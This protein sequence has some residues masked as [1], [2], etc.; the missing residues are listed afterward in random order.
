MQATYF[1]KVVFK[2]QTCKINNTVLKDNFSLLKLLKS[3][4]I[5]LIHPIQWTIANMISVDRPAKCQKKTSCV[6]TGQACPVLC[7]R[8]VA[9]RTPCQDSVTSWHLFRLACVLCR[10]IIICVSKFLWNIVEFLWNSLLF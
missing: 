2:S 3:D 6:S 8:Q 1:P 10:R 9:H 5:T 7:T 4:F